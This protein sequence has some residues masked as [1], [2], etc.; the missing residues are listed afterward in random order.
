MNIFR[1]KPQPVE[2]ALDNRVVIAQAEYLRSN[3][4]VANVGTTSIILLLSYF[5]W[6]PDL[7]TDIIPWLLLGLMSCAYRTVLMVVYRKPDCFKNNPSGAQRYL[8]LYSAATIV[9]G[10]T[11]GYGWLS[12]VPHLTSYEQLIYLLSIV[13][14]LFGG[15]FAYSP[16]LPAYIGF[17]STALWL[18][19]LLLD[20]TS[21]IYIAGLAF[22][23]WLISLVST[24]FAVR[25]SSSFRVNKELEFNV[26][27]LLG[28]VTQKR[29]EAIDAN[30]AKSRFLASVSHDLRQPMQAVSL[31]LNTLQ[32][33]ILRKAGGERAQQLIEDNLMG[34]QH[35]VQYLNAMFEA[36]LDISRLDAGALNVKIEF[37]EIETLLKSLEYEYAKVAQQEGL[38]FEIITPKNF[39]KYQVKVD[40]HLLQRLLRNLI[41]NAIRYTTTGG[42]RV[43][44][45]VHG[46]SVDI[47]V[48]D[49]G[50]GIPPAMRTKIFDEFIQIRSPMAKDKNVGMGLGL[51]IARRLSGILGSR[52]R[53]HTHENMGSVFAFK[54]V[55]KRALVTTQTNPASGIIDAAL[56]SIEGALIVVVDDDP[57]ICEAS[58]TMLELHGAEVIVA[59]SSDSAIQQ[60]VFSSRLPDLILS[61]YRLGAETGLE[62]VERI[63]NEFNED[64][65]A[66]MIT[67]DTAPEE[68]KLL[69]DGGMT[70]L[71]KPVPADVLLQIIAQNILP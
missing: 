5:Y 12:L 50:L 43:A 46:D 7:V 51:S 65:P 19:P 27:R 54:L 1:Q 48:V 60:M 16:Y 55:A 52:I 15:L 32:Q 8:Y 10:I 40:A 20:F 24:M 34:L 64:I 35:S 69:R 39:A 9:A 41:A 56:D 23:I 29:D 14:L 11:F 4:Y 6:G 38:R 67:G 49:T 25:F 61:D 71:Y 26:L 17:S 21:E 3:L 70:V 22:G 37:Q 44:A 47:R 45:R 63:R 59:E 18:S 30:L 13:A 33:L 53:L 42:V 68:L 66:L 57:K 36:L 62:C 2:F 58:K 28:E 31:S